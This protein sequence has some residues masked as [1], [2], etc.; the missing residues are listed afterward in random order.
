MH[1]TASNVFEDL[2]TS[3]NRWLHAP[4]RN[5][6]HKVVSAVRVSPFCVFF[7]IPDRGEPRIQTVTSDPRVDYYYYYYYLLR[8]VQVFTSARTC[9][10]PLL[11]H[12]RSFRVPRSIAT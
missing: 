12:P 3:T 4:N 8:L 6:V 5:N 7:T 1:A 9:V 10:P 2:T 11:R